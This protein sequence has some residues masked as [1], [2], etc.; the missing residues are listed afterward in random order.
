LSF[1]LGDTLADPSVFITWE[2]A[3]NTDTTILRLTVDEME[4]HRG[5]TRELELVWLPVIQGLTALLDDPI[6]RA[7]KEAKAGES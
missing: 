1:T 2:L 4:P 7:T 3:P 6:T 5:S